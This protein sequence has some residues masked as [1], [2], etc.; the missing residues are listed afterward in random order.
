MAVEYQ[1]H[2]SELMNFRPR[3]YTKRNSLARPPFRLII[4]SR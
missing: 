4:E 2:E 1:G 3:V